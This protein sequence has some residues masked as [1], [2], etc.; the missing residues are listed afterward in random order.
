MGLRVL[1][2]LPP[3]LDEPFGDRM[4]LIDRFRKI[5]RR[6]GFTARERMHPRQKL[7]CDAKRV[8]FFD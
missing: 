3:K 8:A 4:F 7:R 1:L 5:A 2:S 6:D